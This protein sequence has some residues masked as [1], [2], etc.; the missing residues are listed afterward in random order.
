MYF[1]HTLRSNEFLLSKASWQFACN[2]LLNQP[3]NHPQVQT[4]VPLYVLLNF[5][6]KRMF[7]DLLKIAS[8]ELNTLV[9]S[10]GQR[11]ITLDFHV[12]NHIRFTK[13]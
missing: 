8:L 1:S 2:T 9:V 13:I 6:F 7:K 4:S 12:V 11:L 10:Q 5:R 3:Q